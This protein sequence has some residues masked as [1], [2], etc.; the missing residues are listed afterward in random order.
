MVTI[1]TPGKLKLENKTEKSIQFVPYKENF[2]TTILAGNSLVL[3][4][5]TVGQYFYYMK[6]AALGLEVSVVDGKVKEDDKV[7]VISVPCKVTVENTGAANV[8]FIPYRENFWVEVAPGEKYEFDAKTSGQ[9]I[10]YL[11]QGTDTLVIADEK[12]SVDE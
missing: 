12:E 11:N 7:K 9:C 10:Y 8:S 5:E 1:V 4:Y 2:A 3:T 6:Q